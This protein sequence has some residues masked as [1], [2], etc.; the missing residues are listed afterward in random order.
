MKKGDLILLSFPF[1]DLKGEKVR[2]ALILMVSEMD[3]IVAFITTQFKWQNQ[4]D[5]QL[6]ANEINGLKKNSLLRLSKITTLDKDLII[7]KL[8][9]L[10]NYVI[11]SINNN[12]INLLQLK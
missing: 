7:G 8:G 5:L 11:N 12:L 9:E 6:E 10:D 4:F 3:V 2:P 1:T